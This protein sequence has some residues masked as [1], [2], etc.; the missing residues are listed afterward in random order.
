MT[1]KD[2]VLYCLERY[3]DTRNSDILLTRKVWENFPSLNEDT[4]KSVEIVYSKSGKPYIALDDLRWL[5]REDHIKRIRANIQNKEKMFLPTDPRVA[6][7]R[8]KNGRGE[9]LWR[10][11]LGYNFKNPSNSQIQKAN[12]Y[13][14]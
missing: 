8:K 9:S 2:Q 10:E 3:P 7:F 4:N 12:T 1:L 6:E 11:E 13:F 5:Q 14:N